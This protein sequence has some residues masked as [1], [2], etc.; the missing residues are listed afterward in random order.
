[1]EVKKKIY[2]YVIQREQ[3]NIEECN[4][5]LKDENKFLDI[6]DMKFLSE[7]IGESYT[8]IAQAEYAI[9]TF[10]KGD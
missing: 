3:R 5:M 4:R 1:M 8:K 10:Y 2:L 9:E 7:E 6:E